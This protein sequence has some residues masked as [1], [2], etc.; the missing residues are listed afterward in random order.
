MFVC[1]SSVG[2][3]PCE[4]PQVLPSA[5]ECP[6]AVNTLVS[7]PEYSDGSSA[8]DEDDDGDEKTALRRRS[9]VLKSGLLL[10][11]NAAKWESCGSLGVRYGSCGHRGALVPPNG[12]LANGHTPKQKNNPARSLPATPLFRIPNARVEFPAK[13]CHCPARCL[14]RPPWFPLRTHR[15]I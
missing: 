9:E 4:Y 10:S 8:D 5:P 14:E 13:P 6:R 3:Y 1:F 7:T 12:S 15:A 2:W 11:G